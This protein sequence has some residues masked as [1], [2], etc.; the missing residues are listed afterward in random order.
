MIGRSEPVRGRRLR[1]LPAEGGSF[2]RTSMTSPLSTVA[3]GLLE[4]LV[5]EQVITHSEADRL[6]GRV[7]D[8]W[9]PIGRILRQRGHISMSQLMDLLQMQTQEPHLRLGELAVREG[10]CTE[11]DT[12][13]ALLIQRESSPHPLEVLLAEVPFDTDRLCRALLRYVRS[14]ERR[15][16]DVPPEG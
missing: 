5:E 9:M 14:L 3:H 2:E 10:H 1:A 11:E 7:R 15:L 16:A 8:G 12:V 13:V 4:I 6:R